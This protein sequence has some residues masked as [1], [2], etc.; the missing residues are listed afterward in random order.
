VFAVNLKFALLFSAILTSC[1]FKAE[2]LSNNLISVE[3][4]EVIINLEK[5]R[6]GEGKKSI[7]QLS[8]SEF[9]KMD[10]QS[11][12]K[13]LEP[14]HSASHKDFLLKFA[15]GSELIFQERKAILVHYCVEIKD[16]RR[17]FNRILLMK[18]R[19]EKLK[20]IPESYW[21]V[22]LVEPGIGIK[23]LHELQQR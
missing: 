13:S 10:N 15:Y 8:H 20:I 3:A 7:E 18:D 5:F 21:S 17:V 6:E 4:E 9:S 23:Q 11:P 19:S 2:K 1:N 12:T 14:S 16:S 22:G